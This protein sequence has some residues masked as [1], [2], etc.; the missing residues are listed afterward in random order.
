M[1]LKL[2]NLRLYSVIYRLSLQIKHSRVDPGR[3]YKSLWGCI[4]KG[5]WCK[6]KSAK[7]NMWNYWLWFS[8]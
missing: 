3:R 5:I 7:L 2:F 1:I 6:K 4:R 8:I